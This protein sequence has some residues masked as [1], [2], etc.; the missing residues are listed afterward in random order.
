MFEMITITIPVFTKQL[1]YRCTSFE[2]SEINMTREEAREI[3]RLYLKG[4]LDSDDKRKAIANNYNNV[5]VEDINTIIEAIKRGG[6]IEEKISIPDKHG[7]GDSGNNG[8]NGNEIN[9]TER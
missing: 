4:Y 7:K 6:R 5:T 2:T 3:E 1:K 9:D 8:N